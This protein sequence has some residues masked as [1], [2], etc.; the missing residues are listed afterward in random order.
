MGSGRGEKEGRE[1][2]RDKE[3]LSPAGSLAAEA[4]AL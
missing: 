1:D 4:G 3:T 2:D